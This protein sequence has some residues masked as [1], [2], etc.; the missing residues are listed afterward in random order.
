MQGTISLIQEDGCKCKDIWYYNDEEYRQCD[1][2][3]SRIGTPW[4]YIQGNMESC[5]SASEGKMPFRYCDV[6]ENIKVE[7][8]PCALGS[9]KS[10]ETI[11]G[12]PNICTCDRDLIVEEFV[13]GAEAKCYK[14]R[15]I[16]C[17][18]CKTAGDTSGVGESGQIQSGEEEEKE[19]EKCVG[20]WKY[21]PT[22]QGQKNICECGVDTIIKEFLGDN[23]DC[24][25]AREEKCPPRT[26]CIP[27]SGDWYFKD[28]ECDKPC[29][30]NYFT[31]HYVIS[32]GNDGKECNLEHNHGQERLKECENN[33]EK[34]ACYSCS[35]EW[36]D[37]S[38]EDCTQVCGES[39]YTTEFV[40]TP[41]TDGSECLLEPV[42]VQENDCPNNETN[43]P[44]YP[45]VGE[46]KKNN[47]DCDHPC[48]KQ[49]YTETFVITPG[50]DGKECDLKEETR[51]VQCENN[52]T[53]PE[54]RD[55]YQETTRTGSECTHKCGHE[56][57][58]ID[59]KVVP[60][61]NG[62]ECNLESRKETLPCD[63]NVDCQSCQGKW[64]IQGKCDQSCG[65]KELTQVYTIE[66]Q[67][68]DG[69]TCPVKEGE[70]KPYICEELIKCQSCVGE[71]RPK[72]GENC[73]HPCDVTDEP[74]TITETFV[75]TNEGTT[76]FCDLK[77]K[78][79]DRQVECDKKD[80]CRKC[81]GKWEETKSCTKTCG[82]EK[83]TLTYKVT[84]TPTDG[85]I[86]QITDGS[87]KQEDCNHPE[88][89]S[90]T[91][92][93]EVEGECDQSCGSKE[94]T[95][96]YSIK[97]QGND[98]I[99]CEFKEGETKPYI[100][101]EEIPC[102]SCV[103][104]YRPK[105]ETCDDHLCDDTDEPKTITE[106][107]VITDMGNAGYCD[108]KSKNPDR[109]KTCEKK[110]RCR[111][112]KGHWEEIIS[113]MQT[114]GEENKTLSW[115]IDETPTDGTE[116]PFKQGETR[117]EA[118]NNPACVSC[119]GEWKI[120]GECDQP[121]GT[122]ELTQ[123][124][125]ITKG[126]DGSSCEFPEGAK[127]V[128]TC[129]EIVKCE[130][131]TGEYVPK[132]GESC[133]NFICEEGGVP[134]MITE[135]FKI[136]KPGNTGV[137]NLKEK[138]PD[139]QVECSRT[140]ACA[141]CV[142]SWKETE[143]EQTCGPETKTLTWIVDKKATDGSECTENGFTKTEDCGNPECIPCV[144][145]W[146]S[147]EKCDQTCGTKEITQTYN[148]TNRGNQECKFKQGE[149]RQYTCPQ[150]T[151]CVECQ[152]EYIVKDGDEC[153]NICGKK[154]ITETF[155]ITNKGT[156]GTCS[157]KE[158][159]PDRVI[160]CPS[161]P[162][163]AGCEGYW[164]ETECEQTCGP[165]TKTLTWI[166]EK[167]AT[168]GSECT[169]NGFTK[170]EDCGNPECIPCVGE[171]V[172]NGECDQPCGTKQIMQTYK[173]TKRGN[174]ECDVKPD[175]PYTCP[176]IREC[177]ECKGEYQLK[178]GEK[179]DNECGEKQVT[180]TFVITQEGT[181]G[182]CNLK[183]QNPD[184]VVNCPSEP[185]CKKCEGDWVVNTKSK[186]GTC[187]DLECGTKTIPD[188]LI[189][190]VENI[191]DI[192]PSICEFEPGTTKELVCPQ[193][194]ACRPCKGK[195]KVTSA[196]DE[197]R[198]CGYQKRVEMFEIQDYGLGPESCENQNIEFERESDCSFKPDCRPCIG[199]WVITEKCDN[200]RECGHDTGKRTYR[201]LDQ[202]LPIGKNNKKPC[203]REHMD[204]ETFECEKKP[205]CPTK[206]CANIDIEKER[207][208]QMGGY[209]DS[210]CIMEVDNQNECNAFGKDGFFWNKEEDIVEKLWQKSIKKQPLVCKLENPIPGDTRFQDWCEQ[211]A[212]ELPMEFSND[213]CTISLEVA[214]NEDNCYSIAEE[215]VYI[216][217]DEGY[218]F[219]WS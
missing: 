203:L 76:G 71:Y 60:S 144:G 69:S 31:E 141:P 151:E 186:D 143:C 169:A 147:D 8:D 209:F 167:D 18:K 213:V 56:F 123:T 101:E 103:G 43:P 109:Q 170:T 200:D 5:S 3:I 70:T 45:C 75:I 190:Q 149:T 177:V 73:D 207:C 108:L 10:F 14:T 176:Q 135:T 174:Q 61:T 77:D 115:V 52:D 11:N 20:S 114:C 171:W 17:P 90:C 181:T 89:V 172:L 148:I 28:G 15:T 29:G 129:P 39:T 116:C 162:D 37:T 183:Q 16:K 187:D 120:D 94:L 205:P 63:N 191:L 83:K 47:V 1:P 210:Y 136:T 166:V 98:G 118:C 104:E 158:Q 126:N 35:G 198:E 102:Q 12:E 81:E 140:P 125:S 95:Q 105:A 13:G 50:T 88:C 57:Y 197:T 32:P 146:I 84:Q 41:G 156:T 22:F 134:N 122:K 27:C 164:Q 159:N 92:I 85:S 38:S 72:A 184:R 206:I 21:F 217:N 152:G 133:E 106:T 189:Y 155:V 40:V 160:D 54:C 199:E 165:E 168:D 93:W 80:P 161:Q 53:K 195:W 49:T 107:F 55:C 185:P 179:C 25:E 87:E 127:E 110:V 68:N 157:L 46:W 7:E 42:A 182:M 34:P 79:P 145:E 44:C 204:S 33:N 193:K 202:G 111:G 97:N 67:G 100:C 117:T 82:P 137:C 23:P 214:D 194:E 150:I 196:C 212:E 192:D 36:I 91:G 124:Y 4:C 219:E 201:I 62:R 66:N 163:C 51:T 128:Y 78:N 30:K 208:L 173:I 215:F 216:R 113:C 24:Y 9:W 2:R 64:E 96:K 19:E 99:A 26:D 132:S 48:E 178:E 139:R 65:S 119:K 131:C 180:E 211:Q 153:D 142:G 74:K 175:R 6:S 59:T 86:C 58:T 218:M 154:E 188:G 121:C 138:N 130:E 112:C